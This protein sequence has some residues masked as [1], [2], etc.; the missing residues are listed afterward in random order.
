VKLDAALRELRAPGEAESLDRVRFPLRRAFLERERV[1]APARRPWKLALGVALL[2]LVAAALSPPGMAVLDSLRDAVGRD[3]LLRQPVLTRLPAKGRLLVMSSNGPWIV[4]ENGAKRRLGD[5]DDASWSPHGLFVVATR[6]RELVALTPGGDVRWT[7]PSRAPVRHPRWAPSGFRIAYLSGSTLRV[8]V[9]NGTGDRLLS[10]SAADIAPAWRPGTARHV[11][12]YFG[13]DR[14]V[15]V[16]DTDR[17]T[18]S[19]TSRQIV[20]PVAVAW[21]A[22]GTLAIL[23]RTRLRLIRNGRIGGWPLFGARG[24]SLAPAP[25]GDELAVVAFDPVQRLNELFVVRLHGFRLI[26]ASVGPFGGI[27]WSPDGRWLLLAWERDDQWLF[28]TTGRR[29]RRVVPLSSVERQF[30]SARG[31]S[32]SVPQPLGWCC[33]PSGSAG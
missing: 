23:D 21:T 13:A 25:A 14:R 19:F 6:G 5:Y 31:A 29:A 26:F 24:I 9:G 28:F 3:R 12:A 32:T 18:T 10:P 2:A 33:A 8:V 15:R 17:G 1:P 7:V 16:V 22:D 11:L 27:A 20:H 30:G 4:R